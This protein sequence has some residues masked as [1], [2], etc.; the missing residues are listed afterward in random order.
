MKQFAYALLIS[1]ILS[2]AGLARDAQTAAET[3]PP[4]A[5]AAASVED[6]AR[7]IDIITRTRTVTAIPE[8]EPLAI[9]LGLVE[10]KGIPARL[11]RD[12]TAKGYARHVV[13]DG[14]LI[15]QLVMTGVEKAGRVEPLNSNDFVAQFTLDRPELDP[16]VPVT[17]EGD[18]EELI[19]ALERLAA[20][21]EEDDDAEKADQAEVASDG[22]DG[23]AGKSG[24]AGSRNQDAAA[25]E[26]PEPLQVP[27]AEAVAGTTVRVTTEGCEIRVDL[28]QLEAIQQNRVEITEDGQVDAGTCED[29]DQRYPIKRSYSSCG[30]LID[31]E[32]GTASAQYLLY[33]TNAGGTRAEVSECQPDEEQVFRIVEDRD[34]CTIQ[35][36][37]DQKQA[38]A[39]AAL[40]YVNAANNE[41]QVRGCQPSEEVAAVALEPVTDGCGIRHDFSA[42]RSYQQGRYI[43]ELNGVT[44]QA[45]SCTDNGTEYRHEALYETAGGFV[46]TPLVNEDTG[47][48]TLQSKV[49]ITV[50]GVQQVISDCRPD[51]DTLA[52]TATTEGCD[53]PATWTHD[54][55]AGISYGRERFYYLHGGARQ[56]VTDCRDSDKTYPHQLETVGWQ[57]HDDQLFAYRVETIYIAAPTGRY[58]VRT[59]VVRQGAPQQPYVYEGESKVSSGAVWYEDCTRL[60]GQNLVRSYR[61]PD[62]T[63]LWKTVGEATPL[64]TNACPPEL[65][66]TTWTLTGA[67]FRFPLFAGKVNRSCAYSGTRRTI[68]DDGTVVATVTATQTVNTTSVNIPPNN[69]GGSSWSSNAEWLGGWVCRRDSGNP[70]YGIATDYCPFQGQD[71]LNQCVTTPTGSMVA[72]FNRAVG[73]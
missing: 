47:T 9:D 50:A 39:Q 19:A 28:D 20:T 11:T 42:G 56:Y 31:I 5:S 22:R 17:V 37:Y 41:V 59:A 63:V 66:Q 1:T 57:N 52:L 36:D 3:P 33:Y 21:E 10:A 23:T 48:V 68:R 15:G 35:I 16:E 60:E 54:V 69:D 38:V 34:A 18:E 43:Y 12:V 2:G 55:N 71:A 62:D 29:G 8:N 44:W 67:N 24:S 14:E 32:A 46:C 49:A 61:R 58:D 27:A 65:A 73:W 53:N 64:S 4:E 70:Y 26:T 40:I 25:Y 45:G 6:L 30:D 7:K 13:V 51:A 72:D